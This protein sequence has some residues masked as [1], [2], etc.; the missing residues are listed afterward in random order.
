MALVADHGAVGGPGT[1]PCIMNNL[2]KSP[3]AGIGD[4]GEERWSEFLDL[5]NCLGEGED[6]LMDTTLGAPNTPP[7]GEQVKGIPRY[8]GCNTLLVSFG[9]GCMGWGSAT[10]VIMEADAIHGFCFGSILHWIRH[11]LLI[12]DKPYFSL[13]MFIHGKCT[14]PCSAGRL[15]VVFFGEVRCSWL[16]VQV[17]GAVVR[18]IGAHG[19]GG[20][21]DSGRVSSWLLAADEATASWAL[22]ARKRLNCMEGEVTPLCAAARRGNSS[23]PL[24]I[25]KELAA[26]FA[27]DQSLDPRLLQCVTFS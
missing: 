17:P 23:I 7:E 6:V 4:S 9:A 27:V 10:D 14:W 18:G 19:R 20:S 25:R 3:L 8:T 22:C 1:A 16:L 5:D 15:P 2:P 12:D 24:W 11:Q 13:N 21:S 26:T